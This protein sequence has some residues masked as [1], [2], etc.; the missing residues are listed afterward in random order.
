MS[1]D[2]GQLDFSS[3]EPLP[4]GDYIALIQDCYEDDRERVCVVLSVKAPTKLSGRIHTDKLSVREGLSSD[5]ARKIGLRRLKGLLD[6]IGLDPS[7]A[8]LDDLAGHQVRVKI[9]NRPRGEMVYTNVEKYDS[10]PK[11][12]AK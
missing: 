8:K 7:M 3:A 6:A 12:W 9:I 11:P 2:L 4:D 10:V 5:E 1:M